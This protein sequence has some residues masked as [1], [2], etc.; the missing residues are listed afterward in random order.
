MKKNVSEKITEIKTEQ[1]KYQCTMSFDEMRKKQME[2]NE[3]MG[4][5]TLT[6]DEINQCVSEVR[7]ERA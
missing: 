2:Y 1:S 6:L 4:Y 3:K 5:P 7:N